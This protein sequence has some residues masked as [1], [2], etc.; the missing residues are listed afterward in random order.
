MAS[1]AKAWNSHRV[2]RRSASATLATASMVATSAIG[3]SRSRAC[4]TSPDGARSA[5]GTHHFG[6]S[7]V[8]AKNGPHAERREK[9]VGDLNRGE[10]FRAIL[11][12][13][14]HVRASVQRDALECAIGAAIFQIIQNGDWK[15]RIAWCRFED[16]NQTV[17][18]RIGERAQ[19]D[20]VHYGEDHRA[21]GH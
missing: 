20:A 6:R 10:P 16:S 17:R 15:F 21:D 2:K 12:R 18:S 13:K 1:T 8:A 4:T 19:Q 5:S 3:S 7:E 14:L 9:V 11:V